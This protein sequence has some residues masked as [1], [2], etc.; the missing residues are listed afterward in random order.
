MTKWDK[1]LIIF[2]IFFALSGIYWTKLM[3][4]N[5]DQL[6]VVIEVDGKEYKKIALDHSNSSRKIEIDTIYGHNVIEVD[7]E[8]ARFLESNCKDQLCVKMGKITK[9]NQTSICLPNRV[10]IKIVSKKS[11]LDGVSY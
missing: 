9:V 6:Y 11:E 2:V 4:F 1:A 3:T 7:G 5:T 10:S 8:G